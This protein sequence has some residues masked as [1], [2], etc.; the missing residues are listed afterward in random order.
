MCLKL[1]ACFT[2][3]L[4]SSKVGLHPAHDYIRNMYMY[5]HVCTMYTY[6]V[7]P[8]SINRKKHI[9]KH[10]DKLYNS[11]NDQKVYKTASTSKGLIHFCTTVSAPPALMTLNMQASQEKGIIKVIRMSARSALIKIWIISMSIP[12]CT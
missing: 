6:N 2:Q 11:L 4:P 8:L 9:P 3:C 7:A 12:L 1:I 5:M 10:K